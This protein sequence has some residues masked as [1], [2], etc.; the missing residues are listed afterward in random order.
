MSPFDDYETVV[1]LEC[2]VQ[3]QTASKLF[4]PAQNRYG[5][6]PNTNV[7]IVDLGLPGVLPVLNEKA[8]DFALRLGVAL[9]CDIQRRSLFAR[10]HYFYPDLPKG[11]QITQYDQ[12]LCLGGRVAIECAD[13]S[14]RDIALTRIHMEEDAGKSLHLEGRRAS[15]CDYNRA[16]TPLLEVVTEPVM[17]SAE[18]AAAFMRA[19]RAI[20]MYLGICDGNL[21]EGSMRADANVSVRKRGAAALGTRTEL[22]NIN[23][24]RFL[25]QAIEYE[26]RRHILELE[27]G[28]P[29][30]T[31]TRLWDPDRKES[32]SMR[33]KEEAH[34]YR[35]FPDPDL[36]PLRVTDAQIAAARAAL[37]EL[38]APKRRRFVEGLGLSSADA[39]VL[40]E[41]KAVADY[42]EAVLA[43]GAP[44]RAAANWVIHEVLRVLKSAGEGD[45]GSVASA[46]ASATLPP[47]TLARLLA[48]LE[49]GT[50]TGKIAKQVFAALW[51][52]EADDPERLVAER[53]W[54]A[55]RDSAAL[56]GVIEEILR[57]HPAQKAQY[58]GGK[59]QLLGF[60]VGQVMRA[61]RGQA[62]PAEVN[63]LLEELLLQP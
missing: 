48:M 16:G 34:D 37:P 28:R 5:D 47:A 23:S 14:A 44:A 52:G 1:G 9:D 56:A 43:A 21:Q 20:V 41:D 22:K 50:I 38:P 10:K 11:Y 46:L 25:A 55:Q 13:G 4:S 63:R 29:I 24:P 12:P 62:D 7:D 18:E 30:E 32:R 2:H 51:A 36:P 57:Q 60:F 26:A 17:T 53:G 8:L 58:Q 15:Y 39:A 33:G 35:Y 61:T 31:E 45:E 3:L 27:A 6:P 49:A 42:F 40:T 54:Q 59:V 19:L